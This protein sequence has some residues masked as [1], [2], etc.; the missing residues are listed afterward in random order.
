MTRRTRLGWQ[1]RYLPGPKIRPRRLGRRASKRR[2]YR[3]PRVARGL[4]ARALAGPSECLSFPCASARTLNFKG[5][6]ATTSRL[7]C[8]GVRPN[9]RTASASAASRLGASTSP[10]TCAFLRISDARQE[11]DAV[12][13][14]LVLAD[15][16]VRGRGG[17]PATLRRSP[18]RVESGCPS[19][20]AK[21]A[22]VRRQGLEICVA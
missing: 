12:A 19:L 3:G 14:G 1:K 9:V 7:R 8:S 10:S 13:R 17:M 22:D 5:A 20:P 11:R 18:E 6:P 2:S 15:R 16:G 4:S 21:G